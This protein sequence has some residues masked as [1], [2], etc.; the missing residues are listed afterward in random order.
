MKTRKKKNGQVNHKHAPRNYAGLATE[1]AAP[2]PLPKIVAFNAVGLAFGLHELFRRYQSCVSLPPVGEKH[3][4]LKP[5]QSIKHL[6]QG[7]GASVP[8]FPAS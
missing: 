4:H 6:F 8:A 2:V 5:F 3:R 7:Y 1:P